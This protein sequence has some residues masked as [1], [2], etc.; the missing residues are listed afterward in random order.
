MWLK[1]KKAEAGGYSIEMD[2]LCELKGVERSIISD[3]RPKGFVQ[4]T[5]P[6]SIGGYIYSNFKVENPENPKELKGV[7]IEIKLKRGFF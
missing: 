7:K 1:L 2:C 6:P 5:L 3:E 4:I